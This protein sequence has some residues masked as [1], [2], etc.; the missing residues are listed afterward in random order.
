MEEE[1]P[2]DGF[3][4]FWIFIDLEGLCVRH[5]SLLIADPLLPVNSK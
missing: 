1:A 3:I 5:Q 4:G 2:F